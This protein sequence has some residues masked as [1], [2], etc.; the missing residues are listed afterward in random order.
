M[1]GQ[2]KKLFELIINSTVF[3]SQSAD[4]DEANSTKANE[5]I[6]LP[7]YIAYTSFVLFSFVLAVGVIGNILVL[8]V[9]LTSK[10]MRSSTNLF[11]LNLSIADLMVLIICCPNAMV[12]MY[13]RRD[14]WVM[15]KTMCLLVPYI[16]LTVSHTSVLTILAITVERYY[17]VCLPLRAGLIWTKKK[18][19]IVCLVS[20]FLSMT[21]TSPILFVAKYSAENP[22]N[23]TCLTDVD[24]RW[25]KVF[26]LCIICLFFWLPLAILILLYAIIASKLTAVET[27]TKHTGSTHGESPSKGVRQTNPTASEPAAVTKG[28]RQIVVML[29]TVVIFF[30]AC[31]LPFKVLTMWLVIS[32]YEIL[33]HIDLDLY[34]NVLYFS[35]LMF[36]INSAINPILYNTMSSRFRE[37]FKRVFGCGGSPFTR[38][39][40]SRSRETRSSHTSSSRLSTSYDI[41]IERQSSM[42]DEMRRQASLKRQTSDRQNVSQCLL[43]NKPKK[44]SFTSSEHKY[45]TTLET[46]AEP[47]QT[48]KASCQSD[49]IQGKTAHTPTANRSKRSTL[50]K[51]TS[52]LSLSQLLTSSRETFL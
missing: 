16:E 39:P 38:T 30:F 3:H 52:L 2:S 51:V 35:R 11:L 21:L 20:W 22:D 5:T 9:I 4:P 18:A 29:G 48:M 25:T 17:A 23:P 32:P 24:P 50:F 27:V 46:E 40:L 33:D 37:R 8:I 15:G 14:I 44:I 19:G 31:L 34:F 43:Q 10:S 41:R 26:F 6:V 28:R 45:N 36:Y 47:T 49:K 1:D 42:R 12:E 13:L 7:T